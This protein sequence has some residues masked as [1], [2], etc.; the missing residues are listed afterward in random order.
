ME[1]NLDGLL[2]QLMGLNQRHHPTSNQNLRLARPLPAGPPTAPR[3]KGRDSPSLGKARQITGRVILNL[4][5]RGTA[6]PSEPAS[7]QRPTR[8]QSP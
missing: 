6:M 5:A 4:A 1:S 7:H 3:C 8:L 2:G